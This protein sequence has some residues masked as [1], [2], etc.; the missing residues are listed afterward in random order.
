MKPL[1]WAGSAL[2]DLRAFPADARR[3]AGH[4]LHLVQQGLEPDDW[5]AIADVGPGV[6]ELRIRTAVEHRVFYVA[7]FAEGVYVLHAFQKK[8]QQIA[9]RDLELARE[10]YREVLGQRRAASRPPRR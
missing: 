7:K 9:K 2:Q 4:E 10:R 1:F 5:K 3:I 6:Y 8:T